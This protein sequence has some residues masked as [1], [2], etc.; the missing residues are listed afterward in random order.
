MPGPCRLL[1]GENASVPE[2]LH[3]RTRGIGGS[4]VAA[5]LGVS[6]YATSWDVFKS[7]VSGDGTPVFVGEE[8]VPGPKIRAELLTDNPIFEW[9]HRLEDAVALKTA[10]ELDLVA[11]SGGGLWQ[12]VDHPLAIVTPDRV[13]TKRRSWKPECL[14]ECKTSGDAEP[15]DVGEAPIQ[16]QV[17]AQWQMGITGITPC[18]LGCFVLGFEREFYIVRVDFDE[19]WFNEMVEIAEDFWAKHV[20][21]NEIPEHD[22]THPRT[23]EILKELHP[24]VIQEA[25]QLPDEALEWVETYLKA[26]VTVKRAE[27][28]LAEAKNWLA[29]H[30]GDAGAGYLGDDKVVSWPEVHQRR[31]SATVLRERFPQIADECTVTSTH[32]RMTVRRPKPAAPSN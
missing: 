29:F 10:D 18:Y 4:E 16:Y 12:H 14:I 22:Y 30:V 23:A 21:T 28:Y 26:K 27:E 25:V 15:W 3:G 9:G 8:P 17:Q 32:R 31:I 7:K 20:L 13:G 19:Q 24:T 6:P 5:L 1:L 11:R 2:W